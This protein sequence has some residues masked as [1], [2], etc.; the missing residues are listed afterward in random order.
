MRSENRRKEGNM[1][2]RIAP[3]ISHCLAQAEKARGR[4]PLISDEI[5]QAGFI[6]LEKSWLMLA[7][8]YRLIEQIDLFLDDAR[9]RLHELRDRPIRSPLKRA[10]VRKKDRYY[11]PSVHTSA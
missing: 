9:R 6:E 8:S 1:L 2:L 11:N 10:D 5:L 4:A 3:Q 7:D